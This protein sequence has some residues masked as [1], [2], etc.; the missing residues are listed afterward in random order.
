MEFPRGL[1]PPTS[2]FAGMRSSPLSYGNMELF[3][4][5]FGRY[6]HHVNR[7]C[8]DVNVILIIIAIGL[9][10][11]DLTCFLGM[12]L[13]DELTKAKQSGFITVVHREYPTP[14]Y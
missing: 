11:L 3:M 14:M 13:G 10:T 1:E 4:Q 9:A 8:G 2:S 5:K 12:K 7:I 6:F